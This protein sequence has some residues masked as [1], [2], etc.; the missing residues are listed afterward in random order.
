[1]F[2][3]LS[4]NNVGFCKQITLLILY[5]ILPKTVTLLKVIDVPIQV[6]NI[7]ILL[8]V[9]SSSIS[10]SR[11][12]FILLLKCLWASRL[13][14][15]RLFIILWLGSCTHCI[16]ACFL[17]SKKP[18]HFLSNHGLCCFSSYRHRF[19]W[20]EVLILSLM[21]SQA[22]FVSLQPCKFSKPANLFVISI[23]YCFPNFISFSFL[24]LSLSP[25][26]LRDVC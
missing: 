7:F 19:P 11:Y 13:T 20:A 3:P 24:R 2:T 6:P 22:L 8:L 1:M 12:S 14:L 17:W 21:F 25:S 5:Y 9:S 18:K 4:Q 26:N 23:W 16:L 10:A 15:F